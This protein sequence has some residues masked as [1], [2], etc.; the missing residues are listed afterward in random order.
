MFYFYRHF[1][2]TPF[3]TV[4]L[5]FISFHFQFLHVV[6]M[7]Y[8][9]LLIAFLFSMNCVAVLLNYARSCITHDCPLIR[10]IASYGIVQARNCSRI[11][12]NVLYCF[13]HRYNFTYNNFLF[14][15]VDSI[16]NS[17]VL[18]QEATVRS[19]PQT[20]CLN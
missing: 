9:C 15:S 10:F 7:E 2:S 17:F 13:K 1:K 6:L 19:A 20:C 5:S 3:H 18:S 14:G 8:A 16:V 11:G 4:Y 12:Q